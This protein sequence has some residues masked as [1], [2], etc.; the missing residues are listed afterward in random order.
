[1]PEVLGEAAHYFDPL[2]IE[3]MARAMMAVINGYTLKQTLRMA[4]FK[5][6]KKYSFD[7]MAEQTLEVYHQVL[8]SL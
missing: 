4:G 7:K 8:N 2:N 5:Q 3:D 6:V 1:M